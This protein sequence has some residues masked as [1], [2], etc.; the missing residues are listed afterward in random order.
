MLGHD[1][2]LAHCWPAFNH[3]D[4]T[5]CRAMTV[6]VTRRLRHV[7]Q[8]YSH[9]PGGILSRHAPIRTDVWS[10]KKT[11]LSIEL[12][13]RWLLFLKLTKLNYL[14]M[15]NFLLYRRKKWMRG[16]YLAKI[17]ELNNC[18]RI[19]FPGDD[20]SIARLSC[21]F[22]FQRRAT[23]PPPGNCLDIENRWKLI[24]LTLKSISI[25]CVDPGIG[26]LGGT[27][28][29]NWRL[30][31]RRIGSARR[32]APRWLRHLTAG[33]FHSGS[34]GVKDPSK[35]GGK[36]DLGDEFAGCEITPVGGSVLVR[37]SPAEW[38]GLILHSLEIFLL[39]FLFAL[40]WECKL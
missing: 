22:G 39:S 19:S 16:K 36:R 17:E 14:S 9:S 3:I 24:S 25:P 10:K 6:K 29:G 7:L 8:L 4:P 21:D 23:L 18:L 34:A 12:L 26:F 28:G 5:C 13:I 1:P 40:W 35:W 11:V 33:K 30:E 32:A 37:I 20:F 15:I 31:I 38:F 2:A 27:R